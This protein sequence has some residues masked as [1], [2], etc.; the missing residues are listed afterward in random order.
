[1]N[2]ADR[3]RNA[4][5]AMKRGNRSETDTVTSREAARRYLRGRGPHQH[6]T[7]AP[8]PKHERGRSRRK[9]TEARQRAAGIIR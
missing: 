4:L 1:M 9:R 3:V 6:F 7:V 5:L 8:D 2:L